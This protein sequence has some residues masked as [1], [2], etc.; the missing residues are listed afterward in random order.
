M[1]AI[2]NKLF[3]HKTLTKQEAK[4]IL[5][6]IS[7]EEFNEALIT[8][9]I[10]SFKLRPI[11]VDELSGFKEALLELRKP[12]DLRGVDAIDVC[13]TGGDKKN[14]FNISTLS[15]FVIA[16]AG[17]KVAKHG[18]YGVSSKCGSSNVLEYLGYHFTNDETVLLSQMDASNICFFHAPLFHPAMKAVGPIRRQL[19]MITFFNMLGPL[20]NPA[21]PSH[22]LVGVFS[23]EL[24]RLYQYLYQKTQIG[25]AIIHGLDGYDEV[26][27]TSAF[28]VKASSYERIIHPDEINMPIV[29][30]VTLHGGE[31][32]EE[33]AKIFVSVLEGKG[34]DAQNNVV[35]TNSGLAIQCFNPEASLSDCIEEARESLLS[36]S[37]FQVLK[38]IT[39]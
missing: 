31:T 23:M 26:S 22:Q 11:H 4:S 16:G 19:G 17:Y 10:T 3:L 30:P 35:L 39:A 8:A 36:G 1:K 6:R 33:A 5:I 27:L 28:S 21:Q 20:V 12:I 29:D 18:N 34:T 38:K 32:V 2:L 14:T 9:F 25:Y 24:A 13:G 37:A 15:S 7:K